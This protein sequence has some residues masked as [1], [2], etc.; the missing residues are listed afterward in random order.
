[1]LEQGLRMTRPQIKRR[2]IARLV[3]WADHA[4]LTLAKGERTE[5][6]IALDTPP[7][8]LVSQAEAIIIGWWLRGNRRPRPLAITHTA[9]P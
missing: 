4:G 9:T 7:T 6:P 1:M 5:Q 2:T 3:S 8:A